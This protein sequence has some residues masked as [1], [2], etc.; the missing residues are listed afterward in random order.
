MFRIVRNARADY[1]RKRGLAELDIEVGSE[2]P[3]AAPGPAV[4]LERQEQLAQLQQALQLIREDR[5][6]LIILARYRGMKY[7]Q[8][9]DLLGTDVGAVK[10]RVHRA[11]KEL[12]DT[13]LRLRDRGHACSATSSPHTLRTI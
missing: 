1:F 3:T 11:V 2:V 7:E 12:R 5:R 13:F 10:V 9:A 6:E 4:L 8:I